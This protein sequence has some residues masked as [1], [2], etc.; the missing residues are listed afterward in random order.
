MEASDA[1]S[2]IQ[3]ELET[4]AF[5]D[6][7]LGKRL[8]VKHRGVRPHMSKQPLMADVVEAALDVVL[9]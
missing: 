9:Q 2:L 6:E 7:R 5:P 3:G 4:A 1:N 8:G